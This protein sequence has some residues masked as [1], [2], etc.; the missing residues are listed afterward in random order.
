MGKTAIFPVWCCCRIIFAIET[1]SRRR[2]SLFNAVWQELAWTTFLFYHFRR[3]TK[4]L[5]K[6]WNRIFTRILTTTCKVSKKMSKIYLLVKI[7]WCF[8]SWAVVVSF[9]CCGYGTRWLVTVTGLCHWPTRRYW[10]SRAGIAWHVTGWERLF[11]W[12]RLHTFSWE[13][14]H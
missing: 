12:K 9:D 4:N 3:S 6:W 5:E 13:N 14:V 7:M 8:V 11:I 1:R 10:R 2:L